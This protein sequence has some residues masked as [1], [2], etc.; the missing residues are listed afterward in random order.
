MA[1]TKKKYANGKK[2]GGTP[3]IATDTRCPAGRNPRD[4]GRIMVTYHGGDLAY[5]RWVKEGRK[6]Y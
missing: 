2:R 1:R 3:G 6:G 4:Y 5:E